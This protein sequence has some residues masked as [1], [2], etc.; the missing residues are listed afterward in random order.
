MD[1]IHCISSS[2]ALLPLSRKPPTRMQEILG[3]PPTIRFYHLL[4]QSGCPLTPWLLKQSPFSKG[5][6]GLTYVNKTREPQV[7]LVG[8]IFKDLPR[9]GE[10]RMG[11]KTY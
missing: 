8:S 9:D 10:V 3:R 11:Y 6:W 4:R 5:G 7:L 2:P 1:K